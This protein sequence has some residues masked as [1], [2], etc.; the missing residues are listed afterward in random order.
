MGIIPFNAAFYIVFYMLNAAFYTY[1]SQV[2]PGQVR[3]GKIFAQY[4]ITPR[5]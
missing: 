2:R 4:L 3:S 1:M 5:I